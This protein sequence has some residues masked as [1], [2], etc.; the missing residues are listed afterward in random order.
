M[1]RKTNQNTQQS[2]WTHRDDVL[3]YTCHLAGLMSSGADLS[4]MHEVLAPFPP[5]AEERLLAAGSFT[6]SDWRA[7]GDGSWEVSTPFV[8]G[9]GALGVGLVAGSLV[10]GA[11][12]RSRARREAAAA[13]VPRWVPIEHG[14]LYV[15]RYSF[16]LHTPRVL[17]WQWAH[18]N[19]AN[20]VGSGAIHFSGDSKNGPIS[21]LLT[22]DW[23]ELVFVTWALQQH[24]RHPQL[25]TGGWLPPG[26]VEHARARHQPMPAN[27]LPL[28]A[29]DPGTSTS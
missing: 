18:I 25:L 16:Y 6:L 24:P 20:M 11:V 12:A 1:R 19:A 9:T 15:S 27:L 28:P 14:M 3:L 8:F 29:A 22:S 17:R 21:W 26:W 13:A 5:A 7:L 23:A 2:G 4:E 10:G